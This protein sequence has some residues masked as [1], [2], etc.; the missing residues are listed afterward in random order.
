MSNGDMFS[1][2]LPQFEIFNT[3]ITHGRNNNKVETFVFGIK[4]AVEHACLLKEFFTQL[5]NPMAVDTRIGVF[6]PN[7]TAHVIGAEAYKKLLCDN[8]EY[9]QTITTILIGDFQHATLNI[10]FSC[11]QNTDIDA[12]NMYET[13]LDQPWCINVEKT[14]TPNKILIITTHGQVLAAREWTDNQRPALYQQHIADKLDV[15]TLQNL[16]PRRLD[17]PLITAAATRYA[18]QLKQ[19]SSY[20]TS[21]A[22]TSPQ[23]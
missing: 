6:L 19:R 20:V 18:D 2:E 9:L 23:F 10:P 11:D 5:R 21:T 8:N 22:T 4:C 17:K 12:T 16:T 1:L 14:M 7:G 3:K 13:I 15:T